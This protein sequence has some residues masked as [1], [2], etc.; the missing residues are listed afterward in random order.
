MIIS[1]NAAKNEQPP[2]NEIT[3]IIVSFQTPA[4]KWILFLFISLLAITGCRK[5]G[6]AKVEIYLLRSYI[7]QTDPSNPG[8]VSINNA[9]LED[10]PFIRNEEIKSYDKQARS[11]RLYTNIK[12]DIQGYGADKA[13]A[14]TVNNDPVYYGRFHPAYLSSMT[15]GLATIDPILNGE[16]ELIMRYVFIDQM[17]VLQQLDKRNDQRLLRA[18]R[19]TGRLR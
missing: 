14:V 10:T 11:F 4:M 2:R 16:N 13:F 5:N 18:L 15:L 8:L 17:P 1:H 9:V 6:D 12:Q 19:E 3:T 7:T